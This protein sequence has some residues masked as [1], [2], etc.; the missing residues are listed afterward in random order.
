MPFAAQ[1]KPPCSSFHSPEALCREMSYSPGTGWGIHE[2][3]GTPLQGKL[4]KPIVVS[5]SVYALLSNYCQMAYHSYCFDPHWVTCHPL[6]R[7]TLHLIPHRKNS[8]SYFL[9]HFCTQWLDVHL[10]AFTLIKAGHTA[11]ISQWADAFIQ[12]VIYKRLNHQVVI[13]KYSIFKHVILV[14]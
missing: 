12:H 14:S 7:I 1:D 2:R 9:R 5:N 6:E 10:L 3:G 11:N 8:C 13:V 4:R